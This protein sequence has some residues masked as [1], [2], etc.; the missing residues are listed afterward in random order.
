M[1][2]DANPAGQNIKKVYR[3]SKRNNAVSLEIFKYFTKLVHKNEIGQPALMRNRAIDAM[4]VALRGKRTFQPFGNFKKIENKDGEDAFDELKSTLKVQ[5]IDHKFDWRGRGWYGTL[6]NKPVSTYTPS[7]FIKRLFAPI[8]KEGLETFFSNVKATL[9]NA[10]G[11][12]TP[13]F[14][15]WGKNETSPPLILKHNCSHSQIPLPFPILFSPS[16]ATTRAGP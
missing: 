5:T 2:P 9:G 10:S 16:N 8:R 4:M 11:Q 14:C 1:H 12:K 6:S 3:K 13:H 7:F 15:L